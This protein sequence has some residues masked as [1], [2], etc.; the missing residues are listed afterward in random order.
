MEPHMKTRL[1]IADRTAGA[2]VFF[3]LLFGSS[4]GSDRS[5]LA[6]VNTQTD[7]RYDIV[8]TLNVHGRRE[9]RRSPGD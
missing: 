3:S 1:M 7:K 8:P 6:T 9:R 2:C 5:G 4:V